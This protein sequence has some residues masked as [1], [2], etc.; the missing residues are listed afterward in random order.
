[1]IAAPLH[2]NEMVQEDATEAKVRAIGEALRCAVCQNQSVYD[3]NSDLA[4]DMLG[5]IRE[6]V[7][8]GEPESDIR[9]YFFDRYGD[10]VYLEPVKSGRNMI[11]WAAP[12]FFLLFG[13]LG[14]WIAMRKWYRPKMSTLEADADDGV[15][16]ADGKSPVSQHADTS[17][18]AVKKRIQQELDGV[19]L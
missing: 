10:Y 14:L 2:A 13:G 6:K 9:Q 4:K 19:E 5:I 8:A 17:Q 1:M 11:L 18:N 7:A 12:F 16:S 3:S 15:A